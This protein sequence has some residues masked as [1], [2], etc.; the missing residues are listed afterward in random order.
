MNPFENNFDAEGKWHFDNGTCRAALLWV[1]RSP[2]V[3]EISRSRFSL[4]EEICSV[5]NVNSCDAERL[6]DVSQV[7]KFLICDIWKVVT[8]HLRQ[9]GAL[10][11]YHVRSF[12][13][14]NKIAHWKISI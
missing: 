9:S 13:S 3:A 10:I 1:V 11:S 6:V 2:I 4:A 12:I 14:G 8:S 7:E 5:R